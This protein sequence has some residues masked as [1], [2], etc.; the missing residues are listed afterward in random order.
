M[1]G[2][3]TFLAAYVVVESR[4]PSVLLLA[5]LAQ[6]R[7]SVFQSSPTAIEDLQVMDSLS[8]DFDVLF[9]CPCCSVVSRFLQ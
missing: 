5:I 7:C 8:P 2:A 9:P 6:Q 1:L 4:A 3:A